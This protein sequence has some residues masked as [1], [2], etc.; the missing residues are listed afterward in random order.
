MRPGDV[1][2]IDELAGY[3]K[4]SK[5]THYKLV[6]ESKRLTQKASYHWRFHREMIKAWPAAS[7]NNSS[8][9]QPGTE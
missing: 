2:T 4:V 3:L 9:K 1:M 7:T 8:M 6:Q 5:S